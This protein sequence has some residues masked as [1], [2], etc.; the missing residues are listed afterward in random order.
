MQIT[1]TIFE[2]YVDCEYK[3]YLKY[4]GKGGIKTELE[5]VNIE[6]FN[7]MKGHYIGTLSS[8]SRNEYI[9]KDLLDI[10]IAYLLFLTM[11]ECH[12]IITMRNMLLNISPG[13]GG[14]L[15]AHLRQ[16]V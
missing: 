9:Q 6:T 16:K 12:G 10:R 14:I 13:I 5:N 11:K 3:G 1:E 7:N 15:M 2:S 4:V 8:K